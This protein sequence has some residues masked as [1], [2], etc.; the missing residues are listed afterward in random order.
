VAIDPIEVAKVAK[1]SRLALSE[2]ELAL[3]GDQLG[4][5]LEYF[6]K[7]KAVDTS[8]VE[9]MITATASGNVF[10]EDVPR[11]GLSREDAFESAP[12]HDGEFFRVPPVIE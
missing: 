7:L 12:D 1:L 9:P 10:R 6:E 4:R 5:I 11:P 3:Y 2:K 8:N